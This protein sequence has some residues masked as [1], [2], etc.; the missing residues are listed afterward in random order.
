M[1]LLIII[2]LFIL[3]R[4]LYM[5]KVILVIISLIALAFVVQGFAEVATAPDL[6]EH[7]ENDSAAVEEVD[8]E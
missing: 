7:S 8:N 1:F 4:G 6:F 5:I 3:Q 2:G